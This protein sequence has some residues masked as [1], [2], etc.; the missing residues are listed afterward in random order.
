MEQQNFQ[1]HESVSLSLSLVGPV[2]YWIVRN[3][4][5]TDWGEDGYL[6]LKFGQ[7]TCGRL[8]TIQGMV[9]SIFFIILQE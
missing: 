2:P 8:T 3:T 1:I 6:R 7:N 5:G 4:W 9:V